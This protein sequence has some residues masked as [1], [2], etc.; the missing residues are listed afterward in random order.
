M[1]RLKDSY[2]NSPM[3]PLSSAGRVYTGARTAGPAHTHLTSADSSQR[4]GGETLVLELHGGN[5]L[6]FD[7]VDIY[8]NCPDQ[9]I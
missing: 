1:T 2:F 6:C 9:Y 4:G 3:N 7:V 8:M 5:Q